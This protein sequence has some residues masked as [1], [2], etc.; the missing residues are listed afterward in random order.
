MAGRTAAQGPA[1]PGQNGLATWGSKTIATNDA[2]YY[3]QREDA[4]FHDVL[5]CIQT[6]RTLQD[7]N[8]MKYE[9]EEFIIVKTQEMYAVFRGFPGGLPRD[10]G[11]C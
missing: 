6:G 7:P 1:R 4:A 9:A 8:R 11:Y 5:L 10:V 3:L 2:P